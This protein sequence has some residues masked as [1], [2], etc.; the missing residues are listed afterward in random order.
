MDFQI[1]TGNKKKSNFQCNDASSI[2][3]SLM[4]D[5]FKIE[6]IFM[7]TEEMKNLLKNKEDQPQVIFKRQRFL[8]EDNKHPSYQVLN[9][10]NMI[11]QDDYMNDKI[12]K[13]D[14]TTKTE[15]KL[16]SNLGLSKEKIVEKK[17][18]QTLP[19]TKA[20]DTNSRKSTEMKSIFKSIDEVSCASFEIAIEDND[21]VK[22]E[23]EFLDNDKV[24][25]NLKEIVS[26]AE[27]LKEC[28]Y[29]RN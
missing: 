25:F 1:L 22:E 15:N 10:Q 18:Q 28:L 12:D 2:K 13:I 29:K 27:K 9:F 21:I 8:S 19:I 11:L 7:E 17:K 14:K 3:L 23:D 24:K 16:T 4:K 26:K 5:L 6:V 20:F